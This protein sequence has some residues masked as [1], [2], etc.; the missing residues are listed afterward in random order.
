[1]EPSPNGYKYKALFYPR[2]IEE[3]G[4]KDQEVCCEILSL[5]TSE[6]TSMKSYKDGCPN[7]I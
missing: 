1:M 5:K 7:M 3:E 6:S 4:E 2:L